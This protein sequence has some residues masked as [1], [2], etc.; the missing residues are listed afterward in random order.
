MAI[1]AVKNC[2]LEG[3]L[4]VYVGGRGKAILKCYFEVYYHSSTESYS[5]E[6]S[7]HFSKQKHSP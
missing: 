2:M 3:Q 7:D 5:I 6:R 4:N 1:S